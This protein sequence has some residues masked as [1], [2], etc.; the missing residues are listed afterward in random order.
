M[1]KYLVALVAVCLL[2]SGCAWWKNY[3]KN[4][5]LSCGEDAMQQ[6]VA[7][8]TPAVLAILSS[9]SPNWASQLK[10]LESAGMAAVLCTVQKVATSVGLPG[11]AMNLKTKKLVTS[12]AKVYLKAKKSQ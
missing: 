3:G 11:T 6:E 7:N 9:G 10:G 5:L 1:K 8:L 2:S 12:R 4:A